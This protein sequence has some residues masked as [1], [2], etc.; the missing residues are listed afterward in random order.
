MGT[1]EDSSQAGTKTLA[2]TTKWTEHHVG[3]V[4]TIAVPSGSFLSA[5]TPPIGISRPSHMGRTA[6]GVTLIPPEAP[7]LL[8]ASTPESE[9]TN[10]E[11]SPPPE[12]YDPQPEILS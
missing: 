4:V 12:V 2:L 5:L 3:D 7:E 8:S 11:S 1:Q 10:M 6:I 9:G